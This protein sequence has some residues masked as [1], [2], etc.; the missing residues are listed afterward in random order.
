MLYAV[1]LAYEGS[2]V[3]ALHLTLSSTLTEYAMLTQLIDGCRPCLNTN[4]FNYSPWR[5]VVSGALTVE[6][7]LAR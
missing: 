7:C 2:T 5:V 6:H 4:V 3:P 1:E